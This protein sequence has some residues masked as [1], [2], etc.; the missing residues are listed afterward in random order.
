MRFFLFLFLSLCTSLFTKPIE[1]FY[2]ILQVEEP[3]LLELIESKPMQRLKEVHQYGISFYT[4]HKEEY[5]R[6][7]HSL[8]VFAILR[9]KGSSLEEQIAGLLHDVSHTAFSHVGE[10]VFCAEPE[11]S[12]Y[13]DDIHAWFLEKY[14]LGAIL[15]KHGYAI[16][17]V[18]PKRELF[19][20]LEQE[21]PNLCADRIEYNLQGAFHRGFLS[22]EEAIEIVKDLQFIEGRWISTKP[23]LIKKMVRFSIYMTK[24]CWG[25]ARNYL[26][27]KWLGEA[28]SRALHLRKF[29]RDEILF[30]VDD[31]IWSRLQQIGDPI[32]Q[33]RF[34]RVMHASQYFSLVEKEKAD[35]HPKMKFRGIDPWIKKGERIERLSVLDAEIF[36]EYHKVKKEM[37]EGWAIK[38]NK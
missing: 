27:S 37:A 16:E 14:G 34:H 30:G 11:E 21:L 32:I 5:S 28:I 35:L 18:L 8:G 10:Y 4:T 22:K 19:P 12:C 24:N 3:V 7:D 31:D 6:F 33:N 17:K 38:F 23:D 20:A 29:S 13:Q 36:K 1:T 9:M 15:K 26:E 25:S 2:G